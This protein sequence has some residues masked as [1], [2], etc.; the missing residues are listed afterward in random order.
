M[1]K[2]IDTS[3]TTGFKTGVWICPVCDGFT[4]P[5]DNVMNKLGKKHYCRNCTALLE[6]CLNSNPKTC[7]YYYYA[8]KEVIADGPKTA[9]GKA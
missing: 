1:Q 8:Y 5:E 9:P 2:G 3:G 7:R 4:V 6:V